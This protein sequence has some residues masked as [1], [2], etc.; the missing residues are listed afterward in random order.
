LGNG[1]FIVKLYRSALV[2]ALA[3]LPTCVSAQE[4]DTRHYIYIE[5][6]ANV[7]AKADTAT[8]SISIS[9][10]A[11][12]S[13][14]AIDATIEKSNQFLEAIEKLGVPAAAIET[15]RFEFEKIYIIAKDSDG[16]PVDYFPDPNRDKFDGFRATNSMSVE[17]QDV[18]QIGSL[19]SVAA[20]LGAEVSSPR[21]SV[22]REDEY[23]LQA[24]QKAAESAL[25]KARLYAETLGAGL[26]DI[27][28]IK[29]GTG[30]NADTMEYAA[31]DGEADLAVELGQPAV[32]IA[33]PTL[34]FSA[35]MA[36]KWEVEKAPG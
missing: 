33:F 26:G 10:K 25:K 9:E 5:A 7:T 12:T 22:T 28:A 31:L 3:L 17:V 24:K 23:T 32:P 15:T 13:Q 6:N 2:L 1:D 29:E 16:K 35:S 18:A 11:E 21:F 8:V 20:G 14:A 27:L 30:Y 4:F 36:V 34:T 19:L